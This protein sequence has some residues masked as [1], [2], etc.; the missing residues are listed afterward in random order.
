MK[1]KVI[2]GNQKTP[3]QHTWKIHKTTKKQ[4]YWTLHIYLGK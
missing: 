1:P 2:P 4:P 3:Q